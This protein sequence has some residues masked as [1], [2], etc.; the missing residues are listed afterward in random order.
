METS[1]RAIQG[2]LVEIAQGRLAATDSQQAYLA[3]VLHGLT[4]AQGLTELVS[5]EELPRFPL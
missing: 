3:G 4:A 5:P 2:A 1:A